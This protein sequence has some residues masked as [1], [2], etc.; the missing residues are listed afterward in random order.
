MVGLLV[1]HCAWGYELTG[2]VVAIAD[3][4]TIKVLDA[5]RKQ[6][7]IRLAGIDAPEKKQPFGQVSKGHLSDLVFGKSV[8]LD[9]GKVD[10]YRRDV[11]LVMVDGM[12][13]DLAQVTAGMAWWSR[14]YQR[15]QTE[16]QRASYEAAEATAR[17]GRIGLWQD[18]NPIPPWVW[19]K[20]QRKK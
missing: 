18:A 14:E 3:G 12:D 11:C 6:H 13:V 2:K 17:A 9:C 5:Q 1:T 4:D 20:A 16:A 10:K 8:V 15:E 19:R 7:K